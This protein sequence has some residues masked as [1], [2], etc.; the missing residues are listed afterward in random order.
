MVDTSDEQITG[1][2]VWLEASG[3]CPMG[4][5]GWHYKVFPARIP[6]VEILQSRLNDVVLW[7]QQAPP[8]ELRR[9]ALDL[10]VHPEA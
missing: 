2:Y 7:P 1:V 4:V 6:L 8:W 5:Q 10:S 9:P 3:D